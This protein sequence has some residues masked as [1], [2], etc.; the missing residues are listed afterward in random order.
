M[1]NEEPRS[2]EEIL[3]ATEDSS[4][5]TIDTFMGVELRVAKVLAAEKIEKSKRL[6]KKSIWDQSSEQLLLESQRYT[7][8]P[9]WWGEPLWLWPILKQQN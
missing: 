9:T 3:P 4:R 8:P 1:T 6:I 5:I 7:N 2:S